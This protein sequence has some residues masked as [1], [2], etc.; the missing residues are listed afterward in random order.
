[1]TYLPPV[2]P[3]YIE[4][5]DI[6]LDYLESHATPPALWRAIGAVVLAARAEVEDIE[7]RYANECKEDAA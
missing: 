1:M 7:A 4:R 5:V 3:S 2:D 6:A